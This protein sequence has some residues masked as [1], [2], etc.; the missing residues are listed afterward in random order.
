MP[1]PTPQPHHVQSAYTPSHP[2]QYHSHSQ[3]PAP[4]NPHQSIPQA[5]SYQ[6]ITPHLPFS[7]PQ[8]SVPIPQYATPRQAPSYQQPLVQ[9]A[10][11]GYKAPQPVEV[12]ILP[13][14]ANASIPAD[15]REQFQRDEQGRVLFF[16]APPVNSSRIVPKEG[17]ALGHSA[18]YLALKAKR[19]AQRAAKRK[20]DEANATERE[21]AAKKARAEAEQ[22]LKKDVAQLRVKAMHA[23]GEQLSLTTMEDLQ[24]LIGGPADAD[25]LAKSLDRL[26]KVQESTMSRNQER[27]LRLQQQKSNSQIPITGMTTRLEED[28]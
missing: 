5:Q 15:I 7:T 24:K 14:H 8:V 9:Q 2:T 18:R 13:D 23:L 21:E 20:S 12:Y 6:P 27:E 25:V 28:I 16:T 3:S 26:V 10:P 4:H 1:V 19:D 17:Q 22:T 11:V